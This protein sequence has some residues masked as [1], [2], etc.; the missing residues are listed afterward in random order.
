MFLSRV[1]ELF[2]CSNAV[3][4]CF[5]ILSGTNYEGIVSELLFVIE[6][7]NQLAA[8]VMPCCITVLVTES[9]LYEL[10]S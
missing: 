1:H 2:T 4:G 10:F 7:L 3:D 9:L 6:C 8:T 5:T